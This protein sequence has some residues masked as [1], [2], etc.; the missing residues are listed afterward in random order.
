MYNVLN[1]T[2]F[3]ASAYRITIC[4]T[5]RSRETD[6][7]NSWERILY[8]GRFYCICAVCMDCSDKFNM[9]SPIN[10]GLSQG[11]MNSRAVVGIKLPSER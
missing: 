3:L 10:K 8:N 1:T 2:L 4:T 7:W 9:W 6:A 5:M 11:S